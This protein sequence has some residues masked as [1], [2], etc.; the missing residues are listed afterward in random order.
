M[1]TNLQKGT[2]QA[3][4]RKKKVLGENQVGER[5][6]QWVNRRVVPRCSVRSPK[7]TDLKDAEGQMGIGLSW[8]QL[9][10]VNPKPFST[11]SARESEWTKV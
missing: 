10:R 7:V 5:K 6:K 3:K 2:K 4:T 11:H 1:D 9:D 8:V